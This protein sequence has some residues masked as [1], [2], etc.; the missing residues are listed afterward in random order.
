MLKFLIIIFLTINFSVLSQKY[1]ITGIVLDKNNQALPYSLVVNKNNKDGVCADSAGNF[2]LNVRLGDSLQISNLGYKTQTVSINELPSLKK[3]VL[4]N[5]EMAPILLDELVVTS[6]SKT[7][8]LGILIKRP[9]IS[10]ST[11]ITNNFEICLPIFNKD[12]IDGKITL[13]KY[14]IPKGG[15]PRTPFRLRVYELNDDNLPGKDLLLDQ[16]I[17]KAKKANEWLVVDLSKYNIPFSKNGLAIS[18][19][20]L[21][22][23]E[24]K[25]TFEENKK[26]SF[27]QMIGGILEKDIPVYKRVN[28]GQWAVRKNFQDITF[29]P[30]IN[31]Q[32]LY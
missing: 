11:S 32:I 1:Q 29:V 12:K 5:L 13:I 23:R 8:D 16:V 9:K 17:V 24:K 27:G 7:L 30:L 3:T 6:G 10:M 22:T 28:N 18:M 26:T 19:E 2:K 25:Y 31:C 4:I 14:Y 21:F 20:W 15:K